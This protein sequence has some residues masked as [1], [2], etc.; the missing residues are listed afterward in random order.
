VDS[1]IVRAGRGG[2]SFETRDIPFPETRAYVDR[3]IQA[4][5]DYRTSY[6]RELGL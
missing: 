3:V 1:W 4:E 5:N 6:S 2:K